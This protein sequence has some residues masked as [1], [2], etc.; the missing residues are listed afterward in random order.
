V[1]EQ[2]EGDARSDG[3]DDGVD[4]DLPEQPARYSRTTNGLLAALLVTVLAVGAF[5]AF[6]GAF[7]D[8]PSIDRDAV[9]YLGT[10]EDAQQGGIELIYPRSLPKGWTTTSIDFVP[11]ERPAWG[12]GV[13]TDDGSFVGLRQED[14]E[15]DELLAAYV[16][17]NAEPGDQ[18][19][20]DSDLSTGPWQTWAD[21][22]GDL[23]YTTS[24]EKGDS[25][26]LG[27]T[28]MV[29]GSASRGDQEELISLLTMDKIG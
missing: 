12:I 6:R 21:V 13:L 24:L 3:D 28:V 18:S 5:V 25:S 23:A 16:D 29:F 17:E 8:Q 19:T 22:G 20:F 27:D 10:V 4:A 2:H 1:T 15:V 26:V 11:G 7:R 9:D 14:A